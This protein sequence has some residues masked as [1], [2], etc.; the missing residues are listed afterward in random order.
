[1]QR[2]DSWRALEPQPSNVSVRRPDVACP[3]VSLSAPQCA[4]RADCSTMLASG[5]VLQV[6]P[7][8]VSMLGPYDDTNLTHVNIPEGVTTIPNGAFMACQQLQVSQRF[9]VYSILHF[10]YYHY[11]NVI[12]R[13]IMN[14]IYYLI[15][16]LDYLILQLPVEL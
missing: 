7:C 11:Y 4:V 14:Y 10:Q 9:R 15:L 16:F 6:V 5:K 13:T 1:M 2:A 3:D 8:T 12:Y